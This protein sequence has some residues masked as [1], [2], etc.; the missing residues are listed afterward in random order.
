MINDAIKLLITLLVGFVMGL[1]APKAF[2]EG[3]VVDPGQNSTYT[4]SCADPIE[5]EDNTPLAA[6]EIANREFWVSTD[7]LT[8]Q[9]AGNNSA[10]CRQVYDLS[11][12][13]DGQYYYTVSAVD[14][15]GRKSMLA[16]DNPDN[17]GGG[18]YVAIVVKRIRPPK[19]PTGLSATVSTGSAVP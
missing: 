19:S 7:K 16:V 9:P 15:D 13:A 12:V 14:T 1:A 17:S 8:W 18:G 3:P 5:R 11:Q 6:G 10:A 4:V 2:A